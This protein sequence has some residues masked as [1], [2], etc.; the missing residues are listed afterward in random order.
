MCSIKTPTWSTEATGG[1]VDFWTG[2]TRAAL[3]ATPNDGSIATTPVWTQITWDVDVDGAVSLTGTVSPNARID[4]I[5]TTASRILIHG[6]R[7]ASLGGVYVDNIS[8]AV[9]AAVPEPQSLAF[10]FGGL[11]LLTMFVRRRR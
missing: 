11:G 6:G 4:N 1:G 8:I 5:G 9:V 7:D 3:S 10:L 2:S